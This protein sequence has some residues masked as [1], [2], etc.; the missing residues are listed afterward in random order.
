LVCEA[1][2]L[3]LLG[4]SKGRN[5]SDCSYQWKNAKKNVLGLAPENLKMKLHKRSKFD[6]AVTYIENMTAKLADTSPFAG[7]DEILIVPYYDVLSVYNDYKHQLIGNEESIV[8]LT[9]FRSAFESKKNIKLL[10]CKGSL[11]TLINRMHSSLI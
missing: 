7:K 1:A 6:S 9:T 2:Y 11:L 3:I 8:S 4:I 10:G 5:A